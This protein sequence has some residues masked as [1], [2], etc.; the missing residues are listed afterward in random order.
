MK[1]TDIECIP[2]VIP[3]FDAEACSSAQD[4]LIV[5][6]HSED[7]LVGIGETDANP[8]A[9]KG[10]IEAPGTHCMGLG[11]KEML[12]GADAEDV[13]GLW[14]KLYEG[15]AMNGRRGLGIHAI[16]ALDMA[17]WDLRGKR[18]GQPVWR[19]LGGA[20][21]NSITPYA[22]L[23]PEGRDLES[24]TRSL[25]E[26]VTG[27][28]KLGFEAA[29]L[30]IC[31]KGPYSH[32]AIQ[33]EDDR[34]IAR[35]AQACREAV[36]DDM[37]LMIDVAYCWP[38]WRTALRAIEMFADLDIYFIETPLPSDDLE[39]CAKLAAASPVRLAMGEWQTTRFE[40]RDLIEQGDIDVV[41][42][43]VGRCG[44]LTEARRIVRYAED[45]GRAVVP[46]CWKSALGIAA[47]AHLAAI[48]PACPY[49]EYL[50][51]E[52]ADS[53]LRI[54]LASRELPFE[55]GKIPLPDSPGLGVEL[56]E[57]IIEKYRV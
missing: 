26:R 53:D 49:I 50:P 9:V 30:E 32:N 51:R 45:R 20:V 3:D 39:G 42:P 22:S 7:G 11:L 8:W 52:L 46:H 19:L 48:S 23:L 18:E 41:Q 25:V 14:Q 15:S 12:I 2:L 56:N 40:F 43:D 35:M 38:D 37:V 1:I 44:G 24:Y 36:G 29:K 4:N 10:M 27:A 54:S 34:E 31:I 13:E 47:S 21:Q 33:V 28:R 17:L 6:I 55:N 16:G 5:R 57:T